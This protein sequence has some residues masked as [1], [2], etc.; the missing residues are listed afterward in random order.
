VFA[1]ASNLNIGLRHVLPAL[2]FLFLLLG[3][4][5]GSSASARRQRLSAALAALALVA[6]ARNVVALHPDYLTFFNAIAGGPAGGSAWLLDSNLDWGQD[7]YRVRDAAA[8]I[9]PDA[10]LYLLYFGHVDPALYGLHYQLLPAEPVAGV[11]AVS[12]NFLGGYAYLTVAPDGSMQGV[13]GD[14]AAWLRP[15]RP[16]RRIGSILLYD[17]RGAHAAEGADGAR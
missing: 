8:A 4:I 2:P 13:A 7:L 3:P 6:T 10:P 15:R 17:T 11:V 9:D 16:A 5:F 14:T 1:T 12:E